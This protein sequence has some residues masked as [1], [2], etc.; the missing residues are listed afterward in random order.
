MKKRIALYVIL[1]SPFVL[2]WIFGETIGKDLYVFEWLSHNRYC[3]V[4]IAVILLLI[5]KQDTA[6][7]FLSVGNIAGVLLGHFIGNFLNARSM[8][9]ITDSMDQEEIYHLSTHY[10]VYIWAITVV[11][12]LIIGIVMQRRKIKS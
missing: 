2:L 5:F 1:L 3:Y 4:W 10:G 11:I 12:F 8:S 6:S 9:Q 7:I